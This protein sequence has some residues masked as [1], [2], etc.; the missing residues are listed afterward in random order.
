MNTRLPGQ[1]DRPQHAVYEIRLRGHL[2][3]RWAP[4]LGVQGLT[5]EDDGTTTLRAAGV[6]QAALHG[7]LL[8]IRNLGLTLVSVVHL[9]SASDAACNPNP[10]RNP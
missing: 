6:D 1:P 7:L 2:D 10:Q 4:R 8:Q 3:A 9:H 5:H